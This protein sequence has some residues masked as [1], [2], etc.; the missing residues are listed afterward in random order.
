VLLDGG[1]EKR[2]ELYRQIQE[3]QPEY[4]IATYDQVI[5]DWPQIRRMDVQCI[6]IDEATQIKSFKADRSKKIKRLWA[7]Y[8][9]ALSG[10]PIENGKPEEV[11][12]I[13]EWVDPDVL[14]RWDLFDATYIERNQF[15]GVLRYKHM[16]AFHERLSTAMAR[17]TV[18]D[19]DVAAY[20]PRV[21][22]S[23]VRVRMDLAT[24]RAYRAIA[25]DLSQELTAAG[26]SRRTFDLA[27]YY[28][29]TNGP[30]ENSAQGRI[31]ARMLAAQM[32]L[33]HPELLRKSST[34]WEVSEAARQR[35]AEKSSW[36]GSQ[37]AHQ[38][39]SC[40][41]LDRVDTTPKLDAVVREVRSILDA[42]P[43][44]KVIVFS[45]FRDMGEILEKVLPEYG[46]VRFHGML[47][48][49]AKA[50]A[51]Q[52]FAT[53]PSCRIFLASDA[54][55]YGLDLPEASHLINIDY[56]ASAGAQDQRNTRHRRTSSA[57]PVVHVLDVLV[58]D[59]IEVRKRAQLALKRRVA[60]AALDRKGAD[61]RGEIQ[62]SVESL[63]AHL[64]RTAA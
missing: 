50:A 24:R 38:V 39:V 19:P 54:G 23:E 5:D 57:W 12:S 47:T 62:Q 11:Y 56:A 34:D 21:E 49:K 40:G 27:A 13:M 51:K 15:G 1:P 55:G 46:A 44:H 14:G 20:M 17:K 33:N 58:E 41:L 7:P 37:Y 31:M 59:T 26:M 8:R 32:L 61:R 30:D 10:T 36:P 2:A 25:D 16:H 6:V 22:F 18:S 63:S 42:D 48:Q 35:G 45:F 29:G 52:Q 64:A 28:S 53:D 3:S 4:I 43:A 60:G 9:F